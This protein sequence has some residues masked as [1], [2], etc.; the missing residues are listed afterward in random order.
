LLTEIK[1][2]INGL[3]K[4]ELHVHL[5]GLV[6]SSVIK[7]IL[8]RESINIDDVN[9]ELD[10]NHIVP[11]NS[12]EEYLQ[13]WKILRR[14]PNNKHHLYLMM[15]SAFENLNNDNIKFVELRH[16]ILYMSENAGLPVSEVMNWLLENIRQLS[17][18]KNIQAGLI[19]TINRGPNCIVDL[20]RLVE[21]YIELGMPKEIIGLD[22]AGDEAI[23]IDYKIGDR[24]AVY[25]EKFDWGITIHAGET[26]N[27]QNIYDAVNLLHA[28]RIGHGTAAGGDIKLMRFLK[29]KD[30]C[31]EV[32]PASNVLSNAVPASERHP[33]NQFLQHEVPFVLCSDNP[34]IDKRSLSDNYLSFYIEQMS[35][36]TLKKMFE[37][38]IHYSFLWKK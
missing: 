33:F 5:N 20:N 8:Y 26:G 16:S 37:L 28:D 14:I 21:A 12:L 1:S 7:N 18:E 17:V 36:E 24:I 22:I 27:A 6:S 13:P 23:P 2:F 9:L 19:F 10:L 3:S 34:A 29:E 35:L 32:C 38:Q 4:G 25:K 15:E 11:C 30:I 31:L